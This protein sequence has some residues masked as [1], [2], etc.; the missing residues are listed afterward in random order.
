MTL[1]CMVLGKAK[2]RR[3][4][5][6]PRDGRGCLPERGRHLVTIGPTVRRRRLGSELR[7]LRELHSL[8]L[9]EVAEQ[10]GLASS[11]L[12]RIETGKAPTRT[13]YLSAMLQLYGVTDPGQQQ[14]LLDMAREGHR[15]GWWA[16]YEDVLPTGFGVYVGLEAEASSVRAYESSVL[17]GLLQTEDYARA[18]MTAVRRKLGPAEIE[19]LVTLR[20]Q[21]QE[22]ILRA[23]PLELWLI[24]D[25]AVLR[26]MMG[27]PELT[28]AQLIHLAEASQWPS[29]T[30]QVLP[31][32]SGLHPSLNGPF[33]IL[34]FP[35]RYDPDVVY[36]EGV[37]GHAFLERERDVRACAET[38][39]LL[40]AA[41]LSPADSTE[42]IRD[43]ASHVYLIEERKVG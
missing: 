1:S 6:E 18:V 26:R 5:G 2:Q 31:F 25:E 19:R 7:R 10:L 29:I 13:A 27:S 20:L 32:S 9:D 39:D 16:A 40:R 22:V 17:H 38:F 37:A 35:E 30:L 24:L 23:D 28:R 4:V 34:E 42:L 8:K 43:L 15:K 33:A 41:A 3:A 21:R 36:T 12:S 14:V 11:T